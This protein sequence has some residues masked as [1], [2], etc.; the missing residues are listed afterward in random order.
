MAVM[1]KNEDGNNTVLT[2]I[3]S[4]NGKDITCIDQK[5]TEIYD[6]FLTDCTY[7]K[8]LTVIFNTF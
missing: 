3:K 6:S 5:A 4:S 7:T 2:L 8:S 1:K